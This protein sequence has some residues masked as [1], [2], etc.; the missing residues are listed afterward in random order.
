M[1][2]CKLAGGGGAAGGAL[3]IAYR[4]EIAKARD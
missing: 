4:L 1:Q 3:N 2:A